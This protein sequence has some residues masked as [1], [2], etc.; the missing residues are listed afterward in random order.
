MPGKTCVL[1]AFVLAQS[2]PCHSLVITSAAFASSGA[3][4]KTA[5]VEFSKSLAVKGIEISVDGENPFVRMPSGTPKKARSS[6]GRET[7]YCDAR[8]LSRSL[9]DSLLSLGKNS[10]VAAAAGKAI[11]VSYKVASARKLTS[12]GRIANVEVEFDSELIV[13]LGLMRSKNGGYWLSYPEYFKITAAELKKELEK[14]V[15]AEGL[16]AAGQSQ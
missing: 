9:H 7:A 13:T 5:D 10:S 8:I 1:A 11:E 6:R 15:I 2:C 4:L 16:K 12:P 3:G 14:A